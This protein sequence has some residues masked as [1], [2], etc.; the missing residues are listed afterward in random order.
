MDDYLAKFRWT[1]ETKANEAVTLKVKISGKGNIKLVESPKITF[2]PDFE[3]YDPKENSNINANNSGVSGTKTFEY[4]IIPRNAGD[5]KIPI[6]S[7]IYFDLEKKQYV[8]IDFPDMMLKVTKGDGN[9]VTVAGNVQR[10]DVQL[11]GKDIRFIKT[12]TPDFNRSMDPIFGSPLFYS[13]IGAPALLFFVLLGVRR[14]NEKL[15]GN[16]SLVKSQRANK[17][18]MKRLSAAKN[19]SVLTKKINSLTKCSARYGALSVTNFRSLLPICQ[20]KKLRRN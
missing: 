15:M 10:S 6:S 11:L 13:L 1:K 20:K 18:A 16:V 7:F 5:F 12:Q 3:S 8:G 19:I 14:R 9:S 4:L 2:P 17:A